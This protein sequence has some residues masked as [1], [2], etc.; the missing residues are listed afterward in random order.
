[1]M[2]T[3]FPS[4]LALRLLAGLLLSTS[5]GCTALEKY[6]RGMYAVNTTVDKYTLRPAAR[7][8]RAVTPDPVEKSVGN[9]F[10]NIGEVNTTVNSILQ[11]KFHNAAISSSRFV[12]NTTLG[13]GGLFDVAS[14]M[15]LKADHEDFGQTL[16]K[17]GLP[18]GPFVV[19]PVAGP[20]TLTDTVG[21]VGD[22]AMSPY[23]YYHWPSTAAKNSTT[24]VRAL[25]TRARLLPVTD[26][27]A[28]IKGDE[29]TFVKSAYLQR[30][31]TLVNDGKLDTKDDAAFDELL[32]DEV[33]G[34]E[35]IDDALDSITTN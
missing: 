30:R 4:T 29:Y 31:K 35:V 17:W 2:T 6:N 12:W 32:L 7:V 21:R 14:F 20:S 9:V 5:L 28:T 25:N 34:E 11:G 10:S 26:K 19:L 24:V 13:L 22:V 23:A 1:M 27:L 15:K 33:L 3:K 8:Y 16:R 18:A